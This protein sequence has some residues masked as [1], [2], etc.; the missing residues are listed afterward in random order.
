MTARRDGRR[1]LLAAVVVLCAGTSLTGCS[2]DGNFSQYPGFAA[3]YAANPPS[4][5]LPDAAGQALLERFKPQ[6]F[7]PEGNEGPIDFYRDYIA[8]G[9]L[10]DGD[11]VMVEVDQET[12]NHYKRDPDVVF[13]HRPADRPVHPVIYGRIDHS[14]LPGCAAP[15]TFLTYHLVF[16]H[17]GLPAA[18]SWWQAIALGLAGNLDDWHQLDHYT[19]VSLALVPDAAGDLA[20]F[21]VTFQ[22]HNYL[23]TYLLGAADGPG[24]L[25]LPA[26]GRVAV[27]VAIRS[28]ELYP[29]RQGRV[30]RRAVSFMSPE[31]AAYL[32]TGENPPWRAADDITEPAR[33]IDPELAF[34]PPADAFYVFQG[35]LGERRALPGRSGPPGADYNT[36][37]ALKDKAAQL[38]AFYW[39]EDDADYLDLLA[40]AYGGGRP[41]T[42]EIG[43]FADRL[44]RKAP[45][46]SMLAACDGSRHAV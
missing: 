10:R 2:D 4:E 21:A 8:Q 40:R 22:Q 17:S 36:L 43:P 19:A 25:A 42:V 7:L 45:A 37:P 31:G 29:H 23:R 16:R 15:I 9:R 38:A 24:Q 14:E 30:Q 39:Y 35:W 13:E 44:A 41:R 20:P 33:E 27:D 12:L 26:D 28:N 5:A 6:I 32:V 3:W 46:G 11:Q 18:L 1:S 34:L